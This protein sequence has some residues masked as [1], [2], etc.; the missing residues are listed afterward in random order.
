MSQQNFLNGW[1]IFY[2]VV[3]INF[4]IFIVVDGIGFKFETGAFFPHISL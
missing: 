3:Y 1:N 4:N 2:S